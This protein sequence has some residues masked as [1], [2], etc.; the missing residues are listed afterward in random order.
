[1]NLT[2]FGASGALGGECL[3]QALEAGHKVTALLRN[4]DKLP[5]E[6][7]ERITVIKGDALNLEDVRTSLPRGTA[8]ILFAIGVDEKTSPRDLCTDVTR[9]ILQVMRERQIPRLVWCGGG[10]SLL[11]EDQM[12]FGARFVRWYGET[13]L[14]HRHDDKVHQLE[15]LH[16]N[17]D[18]TW[19]GIR[20]LQMGLG[21]KRAQYRLGYDK[22]SG[23]SK[24][25]FADCAHAM[26]NMLNDDTWIGKAPIVQY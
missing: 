23:L 24:I 25:T 22:F 21:P 8:A 7:R 9:H 10:S 6:L 17:R 15:L 12:T 13:F 16:A 11:P 20:P 14:K 1:M 4:P 2:L 18:V 3:K 26:I 5:A 19:I